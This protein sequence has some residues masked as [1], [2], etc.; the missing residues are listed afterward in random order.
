MSWNFIL[1]PWIGHCWMQTYAA[2]LV[3]LQPWKLLWVAI[4]DLLIVRCLQHIQLWKQMIML[5]CLQSLFWEESG[6][7]SSWEIHLNWCGYHILPNYGIGWASDFSAVSIEI[8][9]DSISNVMAG[10]SKWKEI[11]FKRFFYT[12]PWYCMYIR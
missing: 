12:C 5:T 3:N 8:L 4:I 9:P 7:V 6:G 11:S 1:R 10:G 2:W